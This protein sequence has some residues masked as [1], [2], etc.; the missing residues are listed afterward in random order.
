MTRRTTL[1]PP[2][3][4][5]TL[6]LGVLVSLS[7]CADPV[8]TVDDGGPGDPAALRVAADSLVV[9]LDDTVRV[10]ALV[11][12]ARARVLA[13]SA[14]RWTSLDPRKATVDAASGLATARDT[15][16]VL[17]VARLG[18]LADTTT[19]VVRRRIGSITIGVAS[20]VRADT[21]MS[22]ANGFLFATVRDTRGA[23]LPSTPVQ[24]STSDSA[25]IMVGPTGLAG[26]WREGTVTVRAS[27]GSVAAERTLHVKLPRLELG[28]MRP[29]QMALG[30][31]HGCVLDAQGR[32]FCWGSGTEGALGRGPIGSGVQP[33]GEVSGDHRFASIAAGGSGTC[34]LTTAGRLLCWGEIGI[35]ANST[36]PTPILD[37][38]PTQAYSV[39]DDGQ[40]C[41]VGADRLLRCWG[42]RLRFSEDLSSRI[43]DSLPRP[44]SEDSFGATVDVEGYGGC[45]LGLDRRPWCWGRIN[46][47]MHNS[48]S[49]EPVGI[50]GAPPLTQLAVSQQQSACGLSEAGEVWCWG[51]DTYGLL[52]LPQDASQQWRISTVPVRV[53]GLPPIVRLAATDYD[54]CG[55]TA[56][57]ELWCWG[58]SWPIAEGWRNSTVSPPVRVMA[59][60]HFRL[61]AMSGGG[62]TNSSPFGSTVCGVTI[63]DD[64]ICTSAF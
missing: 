24:W 8:G 33:I 9:G 43:Y 44:L 20:S 49:G 19:L 64:A 39:G 26:A 5:A 48:G 56:A 32:A 41:A 37:S 58:S 55:L 14:P 36:V 7:A 15:G 21:V 13:D 38:I 27:A 46:R 2:V 45:V 50:D 53:A 40:A 6:W 16:R 18:A 60:R 10:R 4:R 1:R 63:D 35:P 17:V 57:G 54:A 29:V 25:V 62:A 3:V 31:A 22:R 30:A 23:L 34:G 51:V 11:L 28:G 12:D 59:S 61:F 52:G 47:V 42:A